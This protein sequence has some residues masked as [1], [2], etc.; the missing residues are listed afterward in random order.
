MTLMSAMKLSKQTLYFLSIDLFILV[1][2]LFQSFTIATIYTCECNVFQFHHNTGWKLAL[3]SRN[4]VN[5]TSSRLCLIARLTF[6]V[7]SQNSGKKSWI[8][9]CKIVKNKQHH[10]KVL[11]NSFHLNGHTL[12]VTS[13]DLKIQHHL[14]TQGLTLG[15]KGLN[16]LTDF[17]YGVCIVLGK[18]K[19]SSTIAFVDITPCD[20][21]P[22]TLKRGTEETMEVQFT[23]RKNW[24][25]SPGWGRGY[26]L[27]WP[28]RGGS[29]RKG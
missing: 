7:L 13:T 12:R 5:P 18:G 15:V 20:K 29:A 11:L 14:L 27:W 28:I 6:W 16:S 2:I 1:R 19:A 9:F 8:S 24:I 22:C 21:Q 17:D 26:S 4:I 23:P 3:A 10:V 25:R